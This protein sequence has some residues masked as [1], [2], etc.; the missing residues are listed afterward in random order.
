MITKL[1]KWGNSQGLRIPKDLLE[2]AHLAQGD[3]VEL[4]VME[5]KI[6]ITPEK[7]I[8]GKLS[9]KELVARMPTLQDNEDLFWGVPAGKEIW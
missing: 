9:L 5:G 4:S 3:E 1:Q 8:R 7:Q 2:S 6:L